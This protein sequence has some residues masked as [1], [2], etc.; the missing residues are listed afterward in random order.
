M[1]PH[2]SGNVDAE[3]IFGLAIHGSIRK[4]RPSMAAAPSG[5]PG[6]DGYCGTMKVKGSGLG[7]IA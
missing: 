2:R 4:R 7:Q 6:A 3:A 1:D 5:F